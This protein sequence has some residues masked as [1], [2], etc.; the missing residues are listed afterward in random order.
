MKSELLKTLKKIKD[1]VSE[2]DNF[3]RVLLEESRSKELENLAVELEGKYGAGVKPRVTTDLAALQSKAKRIYQKS[4][5]A[6][7]NIEISN[8]PFILF[9]DGINDTIFNF[10]LDQHIKL[11]RET[12][13]RRLLYVYFQNY[14]ED[15]YT[16]AI[17][18]KLRLY[19]SSKHETDFKNLFHK[20]V[21]QHRNDLFSSASRLL[22]IKMYQQN[23][24][25]GTLEQLGFKG[26][27]E[28]SKF[29][30]QTLKEYYANGSSDNVKYKIFN[31]LAK[32]NFSGYQQLL[33]TALDSL[34][35]LTD[36]LNN[37]NWKKYLLQFA[38]QKLGDPRLPLEQT[39]WNGTNGVS[40]KAQ[41]IFLKWLA[42][43]DLT[44]FFKI[45]DQ[46]A[47]DRMWRYR[48][49]FWRAYLDYIANTKV[50]FGIEAQR[51]A[52][53][54]A[55][56]ELLNYGYL[57]YGSESNH[58]AFLFEIGSYTFCE[59][60]HNGKLYIWRSDEAPVH[61]SDYRTGK[62]K[63]TRSNYVEAFVHSNADRYNWQ[64]K[65]ADWLA[66]HCGIKKSRFDWG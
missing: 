32:Q 35:I 30:L 58:S 11:N 42:N 46:T 14:A 9:E 59:W 47:T 24:L 1:N 27:L 54:V 17:A 51:I 57:E 28:T 37:N 26:T 60:S 31:E 18:N 5:E 48:D 64:N 38:Y 7:S 10:L 52:R 23:G 45:I 21:F 19:F 53:Q 4:N 6:F 43:N 2:K 22:M 16:K 39:H 12:R 56:D 49:R 63:M 36:K 61:F 8:L 13:L 20:K 29:V 50:F 25:E 65:V 62:S 55:K 15:R 3:K 66:K 41:Q 44:L 33:P 34:I 40:S